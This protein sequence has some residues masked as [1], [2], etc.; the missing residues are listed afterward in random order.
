MALQTLFEV[1]LVRNSP[2]EV[3]SRHI[4]DQA[5]STESISYARELVEGVLEKRAEIDRQIMLAAP[6]WPLG[7]MPKIDLNILRIAIFEFLLHNRSDQHKS[8]KRDLGHSSGSVPKKVAINE[9]VDLA[10]AFG[11]DSSSRFVNGV[12]S[13]VSSNMA[14]SSEGSSEGNNPEPGQPEPD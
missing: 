5:L 1:D 10:K 3:L 13:T 8:A 9:A 11:G 6:A 4:R 12:L 7:Q 14:K 2:Q